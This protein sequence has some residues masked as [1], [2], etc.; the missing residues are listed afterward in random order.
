MTEIKLNTDYI[1]LGQFLKFS[2]LISNGGEAKFFV[3]E[4]SIIIN[5]ICENKRGKKLFPG[6]FVEIN[7]EK[8]LIK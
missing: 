6:D 4:N 8:F 1:T 7:K 5:G 3:Q 2:G